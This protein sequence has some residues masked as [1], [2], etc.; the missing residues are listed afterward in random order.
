MKCVLWIGYADTHLAIG[1]Y[2]HGRSRLIIRIRDVEIVS[3]GM[4]IRLIC[5]GIPGSGIS[6]TERSLHVTCIIDKIN[7]AKAGV[8]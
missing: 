5:Q 4:K 6:I 1:F 3:H 8:I 7:A 2:D